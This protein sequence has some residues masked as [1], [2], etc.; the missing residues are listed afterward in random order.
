MTEAFDFG[1][2]NA[3]FGLAVQRAKGVEH[4][5]MGIVHRVWSIAQRAEV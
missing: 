5:A 4:G 2:W 1:F 3:D